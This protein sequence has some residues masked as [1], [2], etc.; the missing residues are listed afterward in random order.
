MINE[1]MKRTVYL[2]LFLLF[3]NNYLQAQQMYKFAIG[4]K[5]DRS[6]V[7]GDMAELSLKKFMKRNDALEFN[8]GV[9]KRHLWLETMLHRNIDLK[10]DLDWFFGAGADFGYWNTNYD[11]RYDSSTRSGFWTGTTGILGL[12]YTFNYI[13][14]NFAIDAGPTIRVLPDFQVGL[15]VSFAFRIAI[16]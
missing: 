9:G 16:R 5:G 12:E 14:L 4:I 3:S 10:D 2:L 6:T 1:R 7:G 13:P 15:K 8:L 11:G